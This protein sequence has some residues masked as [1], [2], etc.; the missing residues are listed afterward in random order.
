MIAINARN[1]DSARAAR[2]IDIL[3]VDDSPGDVFLMRQALAEQP[4][5]V[6]IRVAKDGAQ[7]LELV[8]NRQDDPDL[9]ILDLAMPR[10]PGMIFLERCVNP[11]LPVVVFSSSGS[12]EDQLRAL[13]LGAREFIRKPTHFGAFADQ[14]SQIVS[15]WVRPSDAVAAGARKADV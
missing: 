15:N 7:A 5:P 2:P 11:N 3:L 13:R 12:R 1:G 10:A 6:R 4:F 14:V 8:H 9:V